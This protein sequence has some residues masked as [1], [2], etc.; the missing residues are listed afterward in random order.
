[1]DRKV[2]DDEGSIEEFSGEGMK[3]IVEVNLNGVF[4]ALKYGPRHMN[5]PRSHI[6]IPALFH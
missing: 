3:N 6:P 2:A 1:M 5:A 4:Y